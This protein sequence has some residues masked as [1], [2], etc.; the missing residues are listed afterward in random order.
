MKLLKFGLLIIVMLILQTVILPRLNLWGSIPNLL[1]I[2]VVILAVTAKPGAAYSLAIVGGLLLDFLS[3]GPY[4][5]TL[6]LVIAAAVTVNF[7]D[8]FVGDDLELASGFGAGLTL[9]WLLGEALILYFT[10]DQLINPYYL[11]LK[12][13]LTT[14]LNVAL[15][16]VLFP[17]IKRLVHDQ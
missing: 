5:Q 8:K 2:A 15:L 17:L 13:V 16:V 1:L 3:V 14:I 4:W 11:V 10:V 12:L 9:A 7:K 6:S